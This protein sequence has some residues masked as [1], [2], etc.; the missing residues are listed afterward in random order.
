MS[1]ASDLD[2]IFVCDA[3]GLTVKGTPAGEVAIRVVQGVVRLLSGGGTHPRIYEVDTR[4]R[5]FGKSGPLA[6]AFKGFERYYRERAEVAE[7]QMLTKARVVAGDPAFGEEVMDIVTRVLYGEPPREDLREQVLSMRR[8]LE[9]TA[10][11]FDVKRG[12]GGIVDVEFLV[13]YLKLTHGHRLPSLRTPGTLDAL[14]AARRENLLTV[15]EYEALLTSIQFLRSVESR[16]R[17]VYDMAKARLPEDPEELARLARRLGYE[18]SD[19]YPAGAAL[20]EEYR[21]HTGTT[22]KLFERVLGPE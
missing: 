17:I 18:D 13:E 12:S 14:G 4:V 1:Y 21:Y 15:R 9:G 3:E 19:A 7:L 20:L 11:G 5:P 6:S 10:K 8:R 22:R 16:M 2:L